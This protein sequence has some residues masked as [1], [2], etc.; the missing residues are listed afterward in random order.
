MEVRGGVGWIALAGY[1]TG[2]F[3]H[4]LEQLNVSAIR[5]IS[6]SLSS[7]RNT[8]VILYK[9][10]DWNTEFRASHVPARNLLPHKLLE[11]VPEDDFVRLHACSHTFC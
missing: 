11:M 2:D 1:F 6:M 8:F 4:L 10:E 5:G 7:V 9:E 3:Q